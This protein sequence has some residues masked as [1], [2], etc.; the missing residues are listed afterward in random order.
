MVNIVRSYFLNNRNVPRAFPHAA[1]LCAMFRNVF[2]GICFALLFLIPEQMQAQVDTLKPKTDGNTNEAIEQSIEN[3]S[4]T[5]GNE[6]ADYTNLTDDLQRYLERPLNLNK[7]SA[8]ELN[9]LHLLDEVQIQNLLRH[10]EKNGALITIYELQAIDGFDMKTIERILPFVTVY[11]NFNSANISLRE[12]LKNGKHEVVF[13]AQ[14]VLETQKGF[15]TADST[16]LAESPNSR[17]VGTPQRYYA[18]YRFTYSNVISWG[19]LGDKDAGEDFF[20]GT[21][22]QGFDFYSA[23]FCI[24]NIKFVKALVIGDYQANYGQGLTAW[25][26]FAFGKT[27]DASNIKRNAGG[28]RPYFSTD[29]NLFMRGAAT[30][31]RYKKMELSA[32]YSN[33]RVDANVTRSDTS[34]TDIEVL[35]VSSLQQTGLHS[36]PSEIADKDA[37]GEQLMGGNVAYK[38]RKFSI[39][40]TALFTHFSAPLN[41]NLSLYN[42]FEFAAQQNLNVGVDYN[43]VF[44]NFNFFGETGMS[45]NGGL[46]TVN[47]VIISPD[48]RLSFS[49]HHRY[50]QR[51]FQNVYANVFADGSLPANEQGIYMG[52]VAR[53]HRTLTL[54]TFYD[55]FVFPW[56]RFS[57]DA[58][59]SGTDFLV[60]LSYVPD[61]KT[62]MYLRF[63]HRD[64]FTNASDDEAEMDYII[65][66][67]QYNY[68]FNIQYPV[69]PSVKLRNR[70][71]YTTYREQN[72]EAEHGYVI[73]QDVTYRK[74]GKKISFTGRYALFQTE[75][76]NAR[77]Y[78]YENDMLYAYSIPSYY[79][80]GTRVYAL[81]N[82]DITRNIELWFRIAQTFYN[83]QDVISEGS[84]TEI[85]GNRKTEAKIQIR[86]KL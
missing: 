15:T 38:S 50:F 11:D 58:P 57:V 77:M 63:R 22:K 10:I 41:R 79:N 42:Q 48:S 69:S 21:Q 65:P 20:N 53:L 18:R 59:S 35:E 8:E 66:V 85:Q 61:K 83:N 67:E 2:K 78:A 17:Y 56:L 16:T 14:Q 40:A 81:V 36:T 45:A 47:G 68:R 54:N 72:A 31:L 23:H 86:V 7:A 3:L 33:K 29:E 76:Y 70:V 6:D 24:R 30:T 5:N 12:M 44:R 74:L 25:T 84:L 4:E 32:F 51:N 46:A 80:R 28:I 73:Y 39:G 55:R 49:V 60:Q 64:K 9:D 27:A 19:I 43:Y 71:E 1:M 26:G 62:S 75:S 13:R 34:G 82:Y 37:L 52:M